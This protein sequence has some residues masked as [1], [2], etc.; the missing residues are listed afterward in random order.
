[1]CLERDLE[2]CAI[3]S[4]LPATR[5]GSRIDLGGE[6]VANEISQADWNRLRGFIIRDP[7]SRE[8]A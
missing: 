1:M 5:I 8:L 2:R 3:A 4:Q 7:D 6:A